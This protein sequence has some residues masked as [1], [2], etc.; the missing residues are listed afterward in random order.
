MDIQFHVAE[1]G[2]RNSKKLFLQGLMEVKDMLQ[3]G[4]RATAPF[5]WPPRANIVCCILP[6]AVYNR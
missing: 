3:S 5:S 6:R 4:I 1:L 2:V